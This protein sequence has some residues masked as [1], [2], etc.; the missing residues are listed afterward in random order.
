MFC[1]WLV[2]KLSR[3]IT[4]CPWATSRSHRCEPRKPAPPVT[5]M[6]LREVEDIRVA[7]G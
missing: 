7:G 1:F 6:R 4:S 3:Q 5:R 2:K